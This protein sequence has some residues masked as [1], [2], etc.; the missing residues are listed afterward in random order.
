[1]GGC[2]RNAAWRR[3]SGLRTQGQSP[4]PHL[5]SHVTMS[6]ASPFPLKPILPGVLPASGS[7]SA[8]GRGRKR[9]RLRRMRDM[10]VAEIAYRGWQEATK[11]L[12]RVAPSGPY[13]HPE[14]LLRDQCG[15]L[16]TPQAALAF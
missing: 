8:G 14:A 6:D 11:W 13:A 1:M 12:E 4:A 9:G 2:V 3:P 10:R 16:A 7:A 5:K 15:D